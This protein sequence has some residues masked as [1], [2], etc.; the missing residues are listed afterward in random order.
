LSISIFTDLSSFVFGG[1][2]DTKL[3]FACVDGVG[4]GVGGLGEV[5][6]FASVVGVPSGGV[7]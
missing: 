6:E 1:E 7:S 4:C 3:G 5:F 2:L